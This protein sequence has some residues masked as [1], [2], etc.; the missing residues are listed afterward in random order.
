[1]LKAPLRPRQKPN[2][3]DPNKKSV[4]P[5]ENTWLWE[6]Y[7]TLRV[8]LSKA[9]E[10]LT[11]Y[12]QTLAQFKKENELSPD[13]YIQKLDGEGPEKGEPATAEWLKQDILRLRQE[14]ADLKERIPEAVTVSIFMVNIKDIRNFYCGKY[15]QIIE[16]EI[17]LIAKRAKENCYQIT[18]KFGEITD[19]IKKE[20]KNIEELFETRKFIA[21]CGAEIEKLKKA[22]E[23]CMDTYD[24][25]ASF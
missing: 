22:I 4:L 10:P 18:T 8:T 16:R 2:P 14:E 25:A 13:K 15:Q 12:L 1:M 24:I 9:V 5:D 23:E 20:P 17:K 7:D 19:R 21:E 6:A 11:E 3:V